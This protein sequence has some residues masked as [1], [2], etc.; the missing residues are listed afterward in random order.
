M[1]SLILFTTFDLVGAISL[2][3]DQSHMNRVQGWYNL[4]YFKFDQE[5]RPSFDSLDIVE[6]QL[7]TQQA[8]AVFQVKIREG[9]LDGPVVKT[10][11]ELSLPADFH[12]IAQFIFA[13]PMN[14]VPGIPYVIDLILLN[15]T[16]GIGIGWEGGGY[17]EG[18]MFIGGTH[19]PTDNSDVIFQTGRLQPDLIDIKPKGN[20]ACINMNSAGTVQVTI[21]SSD[22]FDATTVDPETVI[23]AGA[24][25]KTAGENGKLLCKE[26]Y[27]NS[28]E[29]LDLI[30]HINTEQMVIEEGEVIIT[31]EAETYNGLSIVGEDSVCIVKD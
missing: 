30:C 22:I 29:Y 28:D 17:S 1:V 6:V 26:G 21:N 2:I 3:V 31:L 14:L 5:F 20:K 12:G 15:G 16:A 7:S 11:T 25:V 23:L 10:S 4:S 27:V 24:R 8:G 18:R 9:S 19:T 13:S